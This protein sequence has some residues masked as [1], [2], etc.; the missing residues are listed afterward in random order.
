[1]QNQKVILILVQSFQFI[2]DLCISRDVNWVVKV[3]WTFE[4]SRL[5][6]D[7]KVEDSIR[8]WVFR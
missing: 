2:Y 8:L 7:F 6:N 5:N 4:T 3:C 1:M